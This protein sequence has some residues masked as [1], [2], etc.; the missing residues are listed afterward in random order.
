MGYVSLKSPESADKL[1]SLDAES[2]TIY[3]YSLTGSD[4]S[5]HQI[6][7][8][9]FAGYKMIGGDVDGDGIDDLILSN[10]NGIS[11]LFQNANGSFERVDLYQDGARVNDV[12]V[13]DFDGD[14]TDELLVVTATSGGPQVWNVTRAGYVSTASWSPSGFGSGGW[15]T[16]DFNG[17][18]L[19]DAFT[20]AHGFS[21]SDMWFS[22]GS[23]FAFDRMWTQAAPVGGAWMTGDFDGDGRTDILDRSGRILLSTGTGFV[24]TGRISAGTAE[25]VAVD[26]FD[27]DGKSDIVWR[28]ANGE[29][30]FQSG[31][32]DAATDPMVIADQSHAQ[33]DLAF[34]G[35]AIMVSAESLGANFSYRFTMIGNDGSGVEGIWSKLPQARFELGTASRKGVLLEIRDDSTG[36]LVSRQYSPTDTTVRDAAVVASLID[37]GRFTFAEYEGDISRAASEQGWRESI[38]SFDDLYDHAVAVVAA[39][40][41][42]SPQFSADVSTVTG[43]LQFV[44]GM[45]GLGEYD[46]SG[47]GVMAN[48]GLGVT[49]PA[50]ASV[51]TYLDSTVGLC[52]DYAAILALFLTKA[53]FENR[54]I[55]GAGHIFN[56]VLVDGQW[57]VFDAM[58]GMA[59]KGTLDDV[60][61]MSNPVDVMLFE[62]AQS[63]PSS[64]VFRPG[65]TDSFYLLNWYHNSVSPGNYRYE[66]IDFL[67][68]LPYGSIFDD[69]LDLTGWT[70]TTP[71]AMPG[72]DNPDGMALGEFVSIVSRQRIEVVLVETDISSLAAESA[73]RQGIGDFASFADQVDTLLAGH[74]G[75][76]EAAEVPAEDRAR[77]YAQFASGLWSAVSPEDA[78]P[79]P[80][81]WP[82]LLAAQTAA[83]E[84]FAAILSGLFANAGLSPRVRATANGFVVE[85]QLGDQLFAFDPVSAMNFVG[86]WN[87]AVDTAYPVDIETYHSVNLQGDKAAYSAYAAGLRYELLSR[88]ASGLVSP[89]Q[90]ISGLQFLAQ[91]EWDLGLGILA[92][93]SAADGTSGQILSITADRPSET[94][95]D[96]TSVSF[97]LIVS[98]SGM[99]LTAGD[100]VVSGSGGAI[101]SVA[102]IDAL[103]WRITVAAPSDGTFSSGLGIAP[104]PSGALGTVQISQA[105]SAGST[106]SPTWALEDFVGGAGID[107]VDF[108]GIWES[109]TGVDVD[110]T[111]GTGHAGVAAGDRFSSI[112]VLIGT[113]HDDRLRGSS[114]DEMLVGG[115]GDDVLFGEAGSDQLFGGDG[116]DRLSGGAGADLLDGGV[117]EDTADYSGNYGA[118]WIDLAAGTGTWNWAHG[119]VLV[120]LE[121]VVG[122]SWGDWLYGSAGTNKL[123]GG[124][125]DD[126]L[127]GG[128]GNDFLDGGTGYD[129]AY[130]SGLREHYQIDIADGHVLV[131]DLRPDIDGDDGQDRLIDIEAVRFK[132]GT[133]VSLTGAP[134]SA[135]SFDAPV[136]SDVAQDGGGAWN[137][138]FLG[139]AQDMAAFGAAGEIGS[140]SGLEGR[141]LASQRDLY[142]WH[143]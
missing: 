71:T 88:L 25:I 7:A 37:L 124:D 18:G 87:A 125:G 34:V 107:T 14:G 102:A 113:S 79:A 97:D 108:S 61:D 142:Q 67:R 118:V 93:L 143:G 6:I 81:S 94:F 73:W 84:Q 23:A 1:M 98:R 127:F 80:S 38:E 66:A 96:A 55:S 8:T 32:L 89:S 120:G 43:F 13:G 40:G 63:D 72:H 78:A 53:G 119:D 138:Q 27:N 39:A 99:A 9:G 46:G 136:A 77:F 70:P 103:T 135:R 132:D 139:L 133:I 109:P 41:S 60:L 76:S 51:Q 141:E 20:Y 134:E 50:D 12:S 5:L 21:G 17:D 91:G 130:Y 128:G 29:L 31:V 115:A 28:R 56:E 57:W 100:F 3:S 59:L 52:T 33:P 68:W 24:D 26:D 36:Q 140:Q 82:D 126:L 110:L 30:Y 64:P 104:S 69:A 83:P 117:G 131:T 92:A 123:Y 16:G 129:V 90:G 95:A 106:W 22:T 2:G 111:T 137:P 65:N 85:V 10:A 101:L 105:D 54:V 19:S 75:V 112:E 86:G 44:S 49:A 48:S 58:V 45:W 62:N 11:V 4:F 42:S 15:I 116:N 122:T 121:N 114:A 47:G 35:D 74:F